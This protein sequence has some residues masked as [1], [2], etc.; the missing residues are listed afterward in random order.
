MSGIV[1]FFQGPWRAHT[2]NNPDYI[3]IDA[4]CRRVC[5]VCLD[6]SDITFDPA[7]PEDTPAR[8]LA[9]RM[10]NARLIEQAPKLYAVVSAL[11]SV[12]SRMDRHPDTRIMSLAAAGRDICRRVNDGSTVTTMG[13]FQVGARKLQSLNVIPP[14]CAHNHWHI[15]VRLEGMGAQTGVMGVEVCLQQPVRGRELAAAFRKLAQACE[16]ADIEE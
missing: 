12:V 4:G 11:W 8:E 9:E 14:S 5:S 7:T 10:A 16:G 3:D 13:I 1:P 2:D 6:T 15:Q